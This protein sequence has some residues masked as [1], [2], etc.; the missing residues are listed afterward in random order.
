MRGV[1]NSALTQAALQLRQ[2]LPEDFF[3]SDLLSYFA[4]AASSAF[5]SSPRAA[6]RMFLRPSLPSWRDYSSTGCVSSMVRGIV[7][8]QGFVHVIGSSMVT[9]HSTVFGPTRVKRS[10]KRR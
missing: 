10:V 9:D 2:S 4:F 5:F 8:V 6:A 1:P 7:N 3:A